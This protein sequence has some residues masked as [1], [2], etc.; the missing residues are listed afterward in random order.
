MDDQDYDVQC[1]QTWRFSWVTSSLWVSLISLVF[2]IGVWSLTTLPALATNYDQESLI[3]ADFS[4]RSLIDSS[5]TK[6]NLLNSNLSNT[7]L[8]GV[9]FFAANLEHA[10]LQGAD[11]RSATLD[12]ARLTAANLTNANLE[13]AFAYN[14]KFDAAIIDGADFTDVDLRA[15][16]Q[17]LLCSVAKGT[18]PVTGRDTRET[19]NCP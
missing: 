3:G 19:L 15:D 1:S 18:N 5:F 6:A 11:L 4:G 14:V 7:D 17:E 12:I 9:S 13:G 16:T 10:N 2:L 8:R